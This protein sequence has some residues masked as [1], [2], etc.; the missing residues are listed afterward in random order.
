MLLPQRLRLGQHGRPQV[1]TNGNHVGPRIRRRLQS[2]KLPLIQTGGHAIDFTH[3]DVTN[4][5]NGR[6]NQRHGDESQQQLGSQFH[7]VK[8]IHGVLP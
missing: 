7:G 3:V 5:A 8:K 1:T 6:G 4:N 2:Q